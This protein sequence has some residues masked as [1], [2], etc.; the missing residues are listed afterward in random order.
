MN[1]HGI[2]SGAIAT[3]NPFVPVTLYPSTGATTD[4]SGLPVPTY[5][6]EIDGS[7]QLQDLSHNELRQIDGLNIQG[8]VRAIYLTGEI[9]GVV[10][11]SGRGGDKFVIDG[12]TWLVAVVSEQWPDWVRAVLVLQVNP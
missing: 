5:G 4:A 1:L 11:L 9:A 8:V 6:A 7:A 3:V 2:V 10:R 12:Q